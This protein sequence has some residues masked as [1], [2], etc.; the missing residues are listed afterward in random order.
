M[1]LLDRAVRAEVY[2]LLAA[3]VDTVDAAV[4][5]GAGG[6][7]RPDVELSLERLQAGHRLALVEGTHQIAMAHPFSGTA[8]AYL[9]RIGD[10]SWFANCAWDALAIV[11]M[12]G[13]GEGR[14]IGRGGEIEWAIDHGVVSPNGIVH[15]VVPA[16][17]FWD[18]IGFT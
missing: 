12:L 16:A 8:S 4:L 11:A 5:S 18:D 13:D 7:D 15:L 9:A 10:R 14:A 2:R 3:G 6:W 17:R 1:M